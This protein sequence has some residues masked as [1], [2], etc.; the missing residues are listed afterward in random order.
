MIYYFDLYTTSPLFSAHF[1]SEALGNMK[2]TGR[3]QSFWTKHLRLSYCVSI[4]WVKWTIFYRSTSIRL[5]SMKVSNYRVFVFALLRFRK[6]L[7]FEISKIHIQNVSRI[8]I[9]T[10]SVKSHTYLWR[11][12][13]YTIA[14]LYVIFGRNGKFFVQREMKLYLETCPSFSS[15]ILVDI[16]KK[17]GAAIR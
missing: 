1:F 17:N 15:W 3:Y 5:Y 11:L 12:Y 2:S 10:Q 4:I 8:S 7:R 9:G 16:W 14:W 6:I 13:K